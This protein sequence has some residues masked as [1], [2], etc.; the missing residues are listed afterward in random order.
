MESSNVYMS[1]NER[2]EMIAYVVDKFLLK[3]L[4]IEEENLKKLVLA[5]IQQCSWGMYKHYYEQLGHVYI[6]EQKCYRCIALYEERKKF[7]RRLQKKYGDLKLVIV[8]EYDPYANPPRIKVEIIPKHIEE[9][10]SLTLSHDDIQESKHEVVIDAPCI[11]IV[12]NLKGDVEAPYVETVGIW[13]PT[14][15][16]R[17]SPDSM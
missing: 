11:E 15:M 2:K 14:Q 9:Q 16:S 13:L 7:Q 5:C 12:E 1:I 8:H 10:T 6:Q 3:K 17:R 4:K